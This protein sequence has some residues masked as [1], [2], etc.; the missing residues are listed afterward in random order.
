MFG[1]FIPGKIILILEALKRM[2]SLLINI[3]TNSLRSIKDVQK[4]L[5]NQVRTMQP[6]IEQIQ[7]TGEL[8]KSEMLDS[9]YMIQYLSN[10]LDQFG[11]LARSS[12]N[13]LG[14]Q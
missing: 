2:N 5:L 4:S 7:S 9:S 8:N 1:L 13:S 14:N 12:L 3:E 6:S 11:H 10:F